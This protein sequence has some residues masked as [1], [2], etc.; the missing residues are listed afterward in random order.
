MNGRSSARCG[1]FPPRGCGWIS[2][3]DEGPTSSSTSCKTNTLSVVHSIVDVSL[4]NDSSK[5]SKY[6]TQG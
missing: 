5:V 6:F 3:D 1:R 2:Y 4:R